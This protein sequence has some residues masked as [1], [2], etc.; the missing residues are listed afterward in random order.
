MNGG[1]TS[2]RSGD[3]IGVEENAR[4]FAES[5]LLGCISRIELLS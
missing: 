5:D 1:E 3:R 2:I 4:R